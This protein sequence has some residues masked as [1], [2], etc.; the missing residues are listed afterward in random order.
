MK[1][2]YPVYRKT[3]VQFI[4]DKLSNDD[5]KILTDYLVFVGITASERKLSQ[6]RIYM[7]QFIDIIE[8]P[9]NKITKEDAD[10]FWNL[11]N[12]DTDREI[13]TKNQI[14]M[15]VKR[16]LKWYYKDT[17]M[18]ENLRSEKHLVNLKKH[19]KSTLI[20]P[21]E[22]EELIRGCKNYRDKAIVTLLYESAGRPE[23]IRSL[24]WSQLNIMNKTIQL[25]SSKTK[26]TRELPIHKSI[27][28]LEQ[29]KQDFAFPNLKESDYIFPSFKDR[30]KPIS[31]TFFTKLI[32]RICERMGLRKITPYDFR[33]SRLTELYVINKVPDLAHRKFAG[34]SPDSKMTAVYVKMDES[35]MQ[36]TIRGIYENKKLSPV[37]KDI[38]QNLQEQMH[39]LLR[40]MEKLRKQSTPPISA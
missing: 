16:F 23:E 40:E 34:H 32:K 37:Q 7:L 17:E 8:K 22:L 15:M 6:Y 25:Y 35:D 36:E 30:D 20:T 2:K 38:V 9:L 31:E 29:W 3:G 4:E 13:F 27:E 33:R 10:K 5:R 19:N 24:K 14:R 18:L 28:R 39:K 1:D 26:G 11:V 12:H 21:E